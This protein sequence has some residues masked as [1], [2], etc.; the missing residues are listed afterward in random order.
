MVHGNGIRITEGTVMGHYFKRNELWYDVATSKSTYSFIATE[1]SLYQE[2]NNTDN[3]T[4]QQSP[5][6]NQRHQQD[7]VTYHQQ[8]NNNYR[9]DDSKFN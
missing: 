6:Q 4:D 5:V 7:R 9:D 8:Y 1:V 2:P 3:N